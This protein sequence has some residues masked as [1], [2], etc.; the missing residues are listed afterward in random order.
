[1]DGM[2]TDEEMQDILVEAAKGE[3][4]HTMEMQF[5]RPWLNAF[6]ATVEALRTENARLRAVLSDVAHGAVI[7]KQEGQGVELWISVMRWEAMKEAI[8]TAQEG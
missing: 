6:Y 2:L 8:S 5:V 1:M 4:Y 7:L 3:G